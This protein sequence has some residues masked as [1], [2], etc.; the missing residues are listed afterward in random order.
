[1]GYG[2]VT[3]KTEH[4]FE[5]KNIACRAPCLSSSTTPFL[6]S[7]NYY[8]LTEVIIIDAGTSVVRKVVQTAWVVG[9]IHTNLQCTNSVLGAIGVSVC[10]HVSQLVAVTFSGS[11]SP[12]EQETVSNEIQ[13][14]IIMFCYE[15]LQTVSGVN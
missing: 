14:V 4:F 8:W 10:A 3:A 6:D 5:C 12:K 2:R 7:G 15:K 9:S 13:A 11:W 1:M